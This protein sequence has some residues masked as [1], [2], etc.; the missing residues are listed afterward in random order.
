TLP[1]PNQTNSQL[2]VL[3]GPYAYGNVVNET[4]IGY[5]ADEIGNTIQEFMTTDPSGGAKSRTNLYETD[6]NGNGTLECILLST[7]TSGIHNE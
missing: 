2:H 5:F 3:E 4:N 1:D 6:P 7:S